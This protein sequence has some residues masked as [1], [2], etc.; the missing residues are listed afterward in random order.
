M[1]R[2]KNYISTKNLSKQEWLRLRKDGIGGS[3][4]SSVLGFNKYR[5]AVDV[6]IDKSNPLH[7]DYHTNTSMEI[8]NLAEQAV[9][10]PFF[11]KDEGKKVLVDHK[12]RIHPEHDVLRATLDGV[13]CDYGEGPGVWEA[14]TILSMVLDSEEGIYPVAYFLQCQHNMMVTGYSFA[15]L[16]MW[17][18]DRDLMVHHRIARDEVLIETI[19][20]RELE[21]W[22]RYVVGGE[23]PPPVNKDDL[24]KIYKESKP[25]KVEATPNIVEEAVELQNIKQQISELETKKENSEFKIQEFMGDNDTLVFGN[26]RLATFKTSQRFNEESFQAE[27]PEEHKKYLDKFNSTKLRKMNPGLYDAYKESA[28]KRFNLSKID[29]KILTIE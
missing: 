21:F 26:E 25:S 4:C 27:Q 7:T 18:K 8:G 6:W 2:S 12:I 13:V 5:T 24:S 28:G 19:K 23:M 3:D 29:P 1:S 20:E 17:I 14:K 16:S 15:W 11:L 9:I 22:E 10:K